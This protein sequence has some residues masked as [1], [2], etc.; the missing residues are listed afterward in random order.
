MFHCSAKYSDQRYLIEIVC[1]W[2]HKLL[3][4]SSLQA[5]LEYSHDFFFFFY[6][7][8]T[9]IKFNE[10]IW[11]WFIRVM[12]NNMF[13]WSTNFYLWQVP[14][15]QIQKY[16]NLEKLY[17][18]TKQLRQITCLQRRTITG[19]ICLC[20]WLC[21]WMKCCVKTFEMKIATKC[22]RRFIAFD[23]KLLHSLWRRIG[24]G[25]TWLKLQ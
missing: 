18:K 24:W 7:N 15:T 11:R 12:N 8:P 6:N 5:F 25:Q 1:R 4:I 16:N 22:S 17:T 3:F 21:M 2:T 14:N 9:S 23:N 10:W 19:E 20:N 13:Q